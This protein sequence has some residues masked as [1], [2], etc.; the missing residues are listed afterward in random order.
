MCDEIIDDT[1][2]QKELISKIIESKAN[3]SINFV[4]SGIENS[5]KTVKIVSLEKD[6]ISVLVQS[7][8]S[9]YKTELSLKDLTGLEITSYENTISTDDESNRYEFL[10]C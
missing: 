3:C 10:D 4:S 8:S 9:S 1:S 7:K 2:T 6:I 5:Y